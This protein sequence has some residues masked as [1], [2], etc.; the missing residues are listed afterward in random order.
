MASALF[1]QSISDIQLAKMLQV[2][3]LLL[4]PVGVLFVLLLYKLLSLMQYALDFFNIARFDLIPIIQDARA[5]TAHAAKLSKQVDDSTEKI[6]ST[7]DK[8]KP[9]VTNAGSFGK[10]GVTKL[11]DMLIDGISA[12]L[13]SDVS[14][15]DSTERKTTVKSATVVTDEGAVESRNTTVVENP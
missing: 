6:K 10:I 3:T 5:I 9:Y 4:I 8:V 12:L 1:T 2:A 7:V 15:R 14:T 11:K 13:K